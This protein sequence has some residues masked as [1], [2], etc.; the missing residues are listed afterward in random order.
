[1]KASA[2]L[3]NY[4]PIFILSLYHKFETKSC[5]RY[6]INVLCVTDKAAS[7]LANHI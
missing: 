4:V 6:S 7:Y 5:I 2:N 3:K 1:M